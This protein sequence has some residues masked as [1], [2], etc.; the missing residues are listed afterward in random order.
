MPPKA[1]AASKKTTT[2][3]HSN[4]SSKGGGNGSAGGSGSGAQRIVS[5]LALL[6]RVHQLEE[7]PK[8]R[9]A[10]MAGISSGTLPS[11]LSRL[12]SKGWIEYGTASGTLKVTAQGMTLVDPTLHFPTTNEEH[13]DAIK[14]KLKGKALRVFEILVDGEIHEKQDIMKAPLIVRIPKRS[15]R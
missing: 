14:A 11:L 7:A 5:A 2:A 13:Q 6:K 9:V 10:R 8:E 4:P 12:K 3:K 1:K 15:I